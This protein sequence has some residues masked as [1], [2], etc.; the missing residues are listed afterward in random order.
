[1]KRIVS[2]V[3]LL[4][5]L[6]VGTATAG[7][8]RGMIAFRDVNLVPMASDASIAHQTV[9]VD[10]GRISRIGPS[11]RLEIPPA[12]V[13]IDGAGKYLI[14]G[15]ADMHV[16]SG[17]PEW[18]TPDLNLFLAHGVTTVRDLTQGP[19]TGSIRRVSDDLNSGRR[20]GPH[21]L[22]AWT[23]WGR[24]SHAA[25]TVPL[26]KANGY[27]CV[28]VNSFFT[29]AE[30]SA[31]VRSAR[32]AGLYTIGHVPLPLSMEDLLASGMDELSHIELL[33]IMLAN[34]PAIESLPKSEWDQQMVERMFARLT[35]AR[36]DTSGKALEE[37]EAQLGAMIAKLKGTGV[38]VTT[39]LVVDQAIAL[40]YNDLSQIVRRP[41]SRYLHPLFWKLLMQ[42]KEKNA[43]FRGREWGARMFYDLLVHSLGEM[44][45][46][47]VPI[48]A[49]TDAGPI[50]FGIVPGSCLH[51]ELRLL[52]ECG[53]SPY[54]ALAAAT[55]D[56]S[57]VAARMTGRDEFGTIE[58]G[59][60]AD[61]L[62]L[63]GNPLDDIAATRGISGV[64]IAGRWLPRAELDRLLE[65][66]SQQGLKLLREVAGRTGNADSVIAEYRRLCRE[67][68]SNQYFLADY[69]LNNVAYEFLNR[70]RV[71]DA[72]RIFTLNSLEYP[73]SA[74]VYDSLAEACLKKGDK[75]SAIEN[76]RKALTMDPSFE[77]SRKALK[78]L[79]S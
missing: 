36:E 51:D 13:V 57:K 49:G 64:M 47:G 46:N 24:E 27:D 9:L 14:P 48:V 69:T 58:E 40:V 17:S 54:E 31:L 42:G 75:A 72:I 78:E 11:D 22:N 59:K 29:R 32:A 77:S 38:T 52:V 18:E 5:S 34:D 74:N 2:C 35:A 6:G 71:D 3:T 7:A 66:R 23:I 61:L 8:A 43:Y 67:N 37:V 21:M 19:P 65:V 50:V 73:C 20:L 55:R 62:L 10:G 30:F 76:Y 15:L 68:D 45:R 44:R 53:Y 70:G 1:M 28:K 79:E 41:D 26:V 25:E 63:E 56:A 39:T 33:P 12:A 4:V 16:H 60:R